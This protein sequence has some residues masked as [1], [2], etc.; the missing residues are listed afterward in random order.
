MPLL[1]RQAQ[2]IIEEWT[3]DYNQDRPHTSPYGLAPAEFANRSNM[4][5]NMNRTNL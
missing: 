4:E 2:A 5:H 3:I 1:P